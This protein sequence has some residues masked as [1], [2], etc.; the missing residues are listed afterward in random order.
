M[1]RRT[2]ATLATLAAATATVVAVA[3]VATAADPDFTCRNEGVESPATPWYDKTFDARWALSPTVLTNHIP[4]GLATWRNY[5]GAG[6]D[7]LVYSAYREGDD[8]QRAW[9]QGVDASDGSRTNYARIQ[10]GHA[11][12]VA[13]WRD[14][15]FVS[16]P[17]GTVYRYSQDNVQ[18][19]FSGTAADNVLNGARVQVGASSTASVYANSFLAIEDGVLFAG[20][21][22]PDGTDVMH[23]YRITSNGDLEASHGSVR[24]PKKTQGVA[25]L[26]NYFLFS[27]SEGRTKRSNLY[28][29]R[30][31]YSS[32]ATAYDNGNMRCVRALPMAEGITMSNGKV[33]QLFESGADWYQFGEDGKGTSVRPTDYIHS[34]NRSDVI[35]L[36][37]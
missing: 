37:P 7:L 9:L 26:D 23:Q 3:P 20:R 6:R 19:V 28:V 2:V 21:F 22:N 10:A 36:L 29:A 32:L 17:G 5:Y 30:R 16:G 34:A 4:Q 15:V 35:D 27:T 31:G 11:G 12:G 13:I 8:S 33:Y 18:A 14:W 24:V 25:V 1:I